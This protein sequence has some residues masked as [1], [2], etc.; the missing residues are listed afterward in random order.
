M[1]QIKSELYNSFWG[2]VYYVNHSSVSLVSLTDITPTHHEFF[3]FTLSPYSFC[4]WTV[5]HAV[6]WLVH[7]PVIYR[8]KSNF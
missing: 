7:N 8:L 2:L 6:C 3:M 5:S 4:P 1:S